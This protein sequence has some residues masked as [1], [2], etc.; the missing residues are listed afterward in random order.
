MAGCHD[1]TVHIYHFK[2][3]GKGGVEMEVSVGAEGY[4]GRGLLMHAKKLGRLCAWPPAAL[5]PQLQLC[6]VQC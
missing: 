2:Q 4:M 3:K 6:V 1:A 5:H